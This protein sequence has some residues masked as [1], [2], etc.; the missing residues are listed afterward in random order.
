M[1]LFT[2]Q[3]CNKRQLA[4]ERC[5]ENNRAYCSENGCLTDLLDPKQFDEA[6]W[7]N[8]YDPDI[9]LLYLRGRTSERKLRLFSLVCNQHISQFAKHPAAIHVLELAR[10]YLEGEIDKE[11][12]IRAGAEA[13]D[14]PENHWNTRYRAVFYAAMATAS[15][16]PWEAAFH[17]A[18]EC[19]KASGASS[20]AIACRQV[21]LIH[22]IFNNPF[23]SVQQC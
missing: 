21:A 7:M 10:Q 4:D 22:D 12:L 3:C 20:E 9:L 17:A 23:H 11:T 14:V 6:D 2:C 5:L 16:N 13:Q 15:E 1:L 8:C 18:A 19:R